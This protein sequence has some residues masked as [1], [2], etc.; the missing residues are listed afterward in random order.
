MGNMGADLHARP[1]CR[2]STLDALKSGFAFKTDG[3]IEDVVKLHMRDRGAGVRVQ[4]QP[5]RDAAVGRRHRRHEVQRA[6]Q[7]RASAGRSTSSPTAFSR[8]APPGN[9]PTAEAGARRDRRAAHEDARCTAWTPSRRAACRTTS[10]VML[11][12]PHRRRPEPQ[13]ENVPHIIWGNGGGYLKTG[14]VHRRRQ[15][16]TNNKLL[17]TLITAADPRQEHRHRELRH[18]GPAR[19][20]H[21]DARIGNR[22]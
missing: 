1:A 16:S 12:G 7:R 15:A 5:R 20:D 17:N 11:D 8:T 2:T 22:R 21:G 19:R 4:L 14:P 6:V 18:R 13:R 9:N 3:M 10:M